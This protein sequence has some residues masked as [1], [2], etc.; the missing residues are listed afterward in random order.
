MGDTLAN[1]RAILLVYGN[2]DSEIADPNFVFIGISGHALKI[3][4]RKW[5]CSQQLSKHNTFSLS[6]YFFG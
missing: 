2:T 3:S 1:D 4:Q 6:L 5:I